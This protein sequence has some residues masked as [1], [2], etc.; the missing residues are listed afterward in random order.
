MIVEMCGSRRHAIDEIYFVYHD[1][2]HHIV[3]Y[4][5]VKILPNNTCGERRRDFQHDLKS[6]T[7]TV[8]NRFIGPMSFQDPLR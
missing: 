2:S 3:Q 5:N 6:C 1:P 7:I 8:V 4:Y